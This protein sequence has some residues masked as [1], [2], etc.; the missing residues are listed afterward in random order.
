MDGGHD[1]ALVLESGG[2]DQSRPVFGHRRDKINQ[3]S[4]NPSLFLI[5][6]DRIE[7]LGWINEFFQ[8]IFNFQSRQLAVVLVGVFEFQ[9]ADV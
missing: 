3:A 9:S 2:Q 5:S 7:S 6:V 4:A 1:L 8:R